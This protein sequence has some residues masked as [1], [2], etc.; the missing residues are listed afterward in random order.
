MK[1]SLNLDLNLNWKVSLS[2]KLSLNSRLTFNLNLHQCKICIC[3]MRQFLAKER[4]QVMKGRVTRS[5]S[6]HSILDTDA[7]YCHGHVCDSRVTLFAFL[8]SQALFV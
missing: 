8:Q 4:D 3:N 5:G 1:M 6:S 2:W 7:E